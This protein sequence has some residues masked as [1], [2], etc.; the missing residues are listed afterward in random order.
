MLSFVNSITPMTS[1][2]NKFP[3]RTVK[4][5][6]MD[7]KWSVTSLATRIGRP[8][9]TVSRAINGCARYPRVQRKV[10]EVLGL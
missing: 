3:T 1:E 7:R 2:H 5:A 9:Q 4:V 6:L 8:R 10:L